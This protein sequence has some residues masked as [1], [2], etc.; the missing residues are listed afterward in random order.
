MPDVKELRING[1]K[2]RVNAEE[3]DL[4]SACC[5]TTSA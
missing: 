1:A 3:T 4:C 5:A 2:V